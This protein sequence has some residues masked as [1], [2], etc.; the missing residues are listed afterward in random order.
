MSVRRATGGERGL[1]GLSE[2]LG[3]LPPLGIETGCFALLA[4]LDDFSAK[5]HL[6]LLGFLLC[7]I[8]PRLLCKRSARG[9]RF[10]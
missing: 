8:Y 10:S 9:A 4:A 5:M 2:N 3:M 6:P 1:R 7:R